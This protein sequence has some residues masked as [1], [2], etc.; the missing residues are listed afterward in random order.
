MVG[1][2]IDEKAVD[3]YGLLYP[4]L[5]N[6]SFIAV[7]TYLAAAQLH[8]RGAVKEAEFHVHL[9]AVWG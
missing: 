1:S 7:R 6:L 8:C 2:K 4:V 3:F 5:G 9:Q